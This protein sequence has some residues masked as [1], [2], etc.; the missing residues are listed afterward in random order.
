MGGYAG[1]VR[2]GST[3]VKGN[4]NAGPFDVS[5]GCAWSYFARWLRHDVERPLSEGCEAFTVSSISLG[6]M[7]AGGTR[8]RAECIV[9][10]GLHHQ[11]NQSNF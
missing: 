7:V 8:L 1:S 4:R 9:G 2:K 11:S 5:D 6:I 3:T 10:Y